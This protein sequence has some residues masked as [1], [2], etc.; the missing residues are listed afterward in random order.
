MNVK[1]KAIENIRAVIE[2]QET[3]WLK[4]NGF[5]PIPHR[6]EPRKPAPKKPGAGQFSANR[7]LGTLASEPEP[8][9]EEEPQVVE[10]ELDTEEDSEPEAVAE[11]DTPAENLPIVDEPD[12]V[13]FVAE[14]EPVSVPEPKPEPVKEVV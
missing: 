3:E 1:E 8:E 13:N 5:E 10:P 9:P 7:F 6:P 12:T 2:Q 11:P 4:E 14:P